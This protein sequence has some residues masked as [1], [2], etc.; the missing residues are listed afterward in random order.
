MLADLYPVLA[1]LRL[2]GLASSEPPRLCNRVRGLDGLGY[3]AFL[4]AAACGNDT[5]QFDGDNGFANP[6]W[7]GS[8]VFDGRLFE[9]HGPEIDLSA[10][11]DMGVTS[12]IIELL[13]SSHGFDGPSIRLTRAEDANEARVTDKLFF[14]NPGGVPQSCRRPG[15]PTD[16]ILQ[17]STRDETGTAGTF[18]AQA[19]CDGPEGPVDP[20]RISGSFSTTESLGL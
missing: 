2:L 1:D 7:T 17:F 12:I 9:L 6:A 19:S 18:D 13:P 11:E 15:D 5:P 14:D 20:V 4:V 3:L 16:P 8:Y 10:D